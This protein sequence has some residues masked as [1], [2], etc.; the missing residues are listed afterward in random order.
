MHFFFQQMSIRPPPELEK[1][2][3]TMADRDF[4]KAATKQ[5]LGDGK[6]GTQ[7]SRLFRQKGN[8][9]E[10]GRERKRFRLQA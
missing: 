2:K 1:K 8:V 5:E 4:L 6:E 3:K 7:N 9:A 10:R